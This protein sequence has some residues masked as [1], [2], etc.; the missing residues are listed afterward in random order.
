[1]GCRVKPGNDDWAADV[2]YSASE[3]QDRREDVMGSKT[4][5]MAACLA[6]L[7]AQ[8]GAVRAAEVSVIASTAMREV[9]EELV[10]MFERASGHKVTL[11]FLSGG[12]LPVK[13]K[14]GAQADLVVTTPQTIDDLVKA[15]RVE[16][17]TRI[18]FVRSGAGV[19]VRAGARKPDIATPDAF[20]NALLAAKT[21]GYSQGPS[22]VHFM[23]VLARLGIADQ[24]KAKGVVPPL[25]QR[26]GALIAKGEAEIGVQQITE[27]LLIPGIDFVGPLP[28]ELQAN[29]VYA[30][31]TPSNA[32]ERQAAAALVK[33]LSSEPALP[34]IKKM[35]LEPG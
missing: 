33:F 26:V 5:A 4:A 13:V 29:I 6:A 23:T 34:V 24:I 22:G 18:D 21:V 8:G 27:L 32:K 20:K 7:L 25:G 14:E 9:L 1:M 31:A 35:G 11:S 28:K 19:A 15:G 3:Q 30:T 2:L 16:A 12:V 17:G 10:P